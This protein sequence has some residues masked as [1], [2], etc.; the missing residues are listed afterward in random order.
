MIQL[1]GKLQYPKW[2]Q[3]KKDGVFIFPILKFIC[4]LDI[5]ERK[6]AEKEK[7]KLESQLRQALDEAK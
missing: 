1:K 5:T 6:Q 7:E 2:A 4:S 3:I